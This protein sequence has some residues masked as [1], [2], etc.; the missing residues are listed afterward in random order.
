VLIGAAFAYLQFSEQQETAREQLQ[1]TV[2]QVE[3]QQRAARD[4]LISNQ[5][6]KGFELLGNKDNQNQKRLGGI[7]ALEGE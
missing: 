4:L 3:Q 7:Y 1:A 5:V 2:Q 6:A